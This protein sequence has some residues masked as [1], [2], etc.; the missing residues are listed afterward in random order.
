MPRPSLS[1][2]LTTTNRNTWEALEGQPGAAQAGL[3]PVQIA[4][5]GGSGRVIT[6]TRIE[7]DVTRSQRP[8]GAV[9]IGAC[10]GPIEGRSLEVDLDLNPPRVVD[11]NAT[12]DG[13][14]GARESDGIRPY[15]PIRFPWTV[16]V[17]DPLLL[18]IIATT[19]ACDCT[20]TGE[21]FWV[22][23]DS[24]GTIAID[25]EGDGYRVVG[26]EG[27]PSYAPSV[28]GWRRWEY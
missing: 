11:S 3:N 10:G 5:Q 9:F 24:Q 25:N 6:L 22:S 21:I 26:S 17:S 14:L 13:A 20:W 15:R 8:P 7:F 28:S 4:I 27:V 2:A 23:G 16:S 19:A 12:E 18:E 1:T